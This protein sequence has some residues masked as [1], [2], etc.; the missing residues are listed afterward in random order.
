MDLLLATIFSIIPLALLVLVERS[1]Y[2]RYRKALVKKPKLKARSTAIWISL[3][4]LGTFPAL[5]LMALLLYMSSQTGFVGMEITGTLLFGWFVI[6]KEKVFLLF[7][8]WEVI[9]QAGA[10]VILAL[11]AFQWF[12]EWRFRDKSARRL[13]GRKQGWPIRWTVGLAATVLLVLAAGYGFLGAATQTAG[14][15]REPVAQYHT[16]R[17][18]DSDTRSNLHNVYLACKVFWADHGSNASCEREAFTQVDYGYIQSADVRIDA[19]GSEKE[20]RAVATNINSKQW[21]WVNE[22]GT[23]QP[24]D[25]TVLNS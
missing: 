8:H 21:F 6:L 17:S 22:Q 25:I 4:L 12:M 9:T 1:L 23:I 11:I 15:I 7:P 10:L 14:L 24:L 2:R 16:G 20:F 5:F 18:Y 13:P 19:R 3:S